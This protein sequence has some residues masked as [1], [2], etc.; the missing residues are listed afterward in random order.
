MK[1]TYQSDKNSA[2]VSDP[3][4]L[5]HLHSYVHANFPLPPSPPLPIILYFFSSFSILL[6]FF[7][8]I[9]M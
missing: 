3:G 8:E 1:F 6:P 2:L 4:A 9:L 7:F 5:S